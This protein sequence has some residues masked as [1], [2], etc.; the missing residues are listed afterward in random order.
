MKRN[1][2]AVGAQEDRLL[3]VAEL[4]AL[5]GIPQQTFYRWRTDGRGPRAIKIG[6]HLRYRRSDIDEWLESQADQRPPAA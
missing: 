3:D 6:K 1:T 2:V 5:V 4:S